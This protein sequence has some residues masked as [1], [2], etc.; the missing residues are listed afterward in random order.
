MTS[1]QPKWPNLWALAFQKMTSVTR[2]EWQVTFAPTLAP[3]FPETSDKGSLH[4]PLPLYSP[5]QASAPTLTPPSLVPS[6]KGS[7]HPPSPL[8]HLKRATRGLCA[9][10]DPPMARNERRGP[11]L[12]D[13]S[14]EGSPHPPLPLLSPPFNAPTL[15]PPTSLEPPTSTLGCSKRAHHRHSLARTRKGGFPAT[16]SLF[17][18]TRGLCL[19]VHIFCS[20]QCSEPFMT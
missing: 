17:D 12:T 13:P 19:F 1:C 10:L 11:T 9:H 20:F 8:R 2:N 3:P 18:V 15:T 5:K 14:L 7:L 16:L 4:P 6:D